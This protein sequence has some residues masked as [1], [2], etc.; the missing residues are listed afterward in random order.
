MVS[1]GKWF[2][3]TTGTFLEA[4]NVSL[5]RWVYFAREVDKGRAAG[6]IGEEIGVTRKT[7]RRMAKKLF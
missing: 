5:R 6:P 7:A 1:C 4:T 2:I 3:D